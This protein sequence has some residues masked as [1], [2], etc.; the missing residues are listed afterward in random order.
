MFRLAAAALLLI[1][2]D[3]RPSATSA[4]GASEGPGPASK[5]GRQQL[6]ADE[7][8]D[9]RKLDG[10]WRV[11]K[12]ERDGKG[13]PSL[14]AATHFL[15]TQGRLY[16]GPPNEFYDP[17]FTFRADAT[18][19]PAAIDL[20]DAED[21]T[22]RGIYRVGREGITLCWSTEPYG[23][24]PGEFAV[25]PG[26]KLRLV[27]L[28]RWDKHKIKGDWRLVGGEVDGAP[29]EPEEVE[30]VRLDTT[31]SPF[32]PRLPTRTEE[33]WLSLEEHE[34]PRTLTA[35]VRRTV[36]GRDVADERW[37]A[38]YELGGDQLTVCVGPEAAPPG[39]FATRR[40]QG[41]KLLV[42]RR[43]ARKEAAPSKD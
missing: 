1:G 41:H 16:L 32:V 4:A 42:F 20:T 39:R 38:V 10:D 12:T 33:G 40:G 5:E 37:A 3:D 31:R 26:S 9:P 7:A 34:T 35:T 6:G 24:R 11:G 21:R 36:N 23:R 15:F 14:S 29:L 19:R 18:K 30:R 13:A 27:V 8:A 28:A 43:A 25:P 22:F 17:F 2:A